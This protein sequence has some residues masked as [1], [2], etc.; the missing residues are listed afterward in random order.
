MLFCKPIKI[1][2]TTKELFRIDDDFMKEKCVKWSDCVGVCTDAAC[3]IAGNKGGLQALIKRSA[4]EAM[5]THCM[6]HHESPA[7]KE[8]CP[9][10]S[11]VMDTVIRSVNYIKTCPLKNRL[12]A[13]L[14]TEMGAQFQSLL[15][16]CN[17]R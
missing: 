6:I 1:R 10:L 15:F 8:L 4:P 9:E 16:Y 3:I 17:S 12:F 7:M 2:A 14:C 11:E 5:W 13:E